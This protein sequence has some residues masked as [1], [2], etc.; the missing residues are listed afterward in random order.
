[1]GRQALHFHSA[2]HTKLYYYVMVL[3]AM[4]LLSFDA[5]VV[6]ASEGQNVQHLKMISVIEYTGKGQFRNQAENLFEVRKE[7]LSKNEFQYFITGNDSC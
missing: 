4:F 7:A 2:L 1:L 3:I 5:K 6:L